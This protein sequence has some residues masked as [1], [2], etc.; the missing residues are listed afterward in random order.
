MTEKQRQENKIVELK[1]R[2]TKED[3]TQCTIWTAKRL[4]SCNAHTYRVNNLVF[5]QSYQ[6]VVAVIDL[7]TETCYDW[8]RLVYGYTA[9]SAQHISKFMKKYGIVRKKTWKD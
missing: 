3:S 6:T 2:F 1:H 9:T 8:L 7:N 5:L 4:Y